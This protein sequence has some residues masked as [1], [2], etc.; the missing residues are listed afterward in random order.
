I[1]LEASNGAL[2][3]AAGDSPDG[4]TASVIKANATLDLYNK[5]AIPIPTPPD[6]RV[7]ANHA[8]AHIFIDTSGNVT[9]AGIRSAGDMALYADRGTITMSAVGTGKDIYREALAAAASAVSNLFG[10]GNVT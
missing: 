1:R 8:P 7:G 4:L 2:T 3:I 5:T 6:P 9:N 10:G